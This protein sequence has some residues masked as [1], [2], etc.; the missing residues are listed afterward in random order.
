VRI[1]VQNYQ[2]LTRFDKMFQRKGVQPPEPPMD[3]PLR[4]NFYVCFPPCRFSLQNMSKHACLGE[5]R[6]VPVLPS[7]TIRIR[8]RMFLLPIKV[9]QGANSLIQWLKWLETYKDTCK[10]TRAQKTKKTYLCSVTARPDQSLSNTTINQFTF[11]ITC[12]I[13][14]IIHLT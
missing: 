8:I 9:P 14:I 2:F 6:N 5:R 7:V 12:I 4:C 11:N 10:H 3:P 13:T 1:P